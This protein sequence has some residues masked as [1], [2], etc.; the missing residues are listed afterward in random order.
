MQRGTSIFNLA[1]IQNLFNAALLPE[2]ASV[3]LS[4]RTIMLISSWRKLSSLICTLL[5]PVMTTKPPHSCL[6]GP[7]FPIH[8]RH[9]MFLRLNTSSPTHILCS[10]PLTKFYSSFSNHTLPSNLHTNSS[11]RTY[12]TPVIPAE[13]HTPVQTLDATISYT[14]DACHGLATGLYLRASCKR[15]KV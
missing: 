5:I 4:H 15:K 8:P 7:P 10:S 14:P 3:V 13:E 11:K 9:L 1:Q 6:S 12:I 2:T